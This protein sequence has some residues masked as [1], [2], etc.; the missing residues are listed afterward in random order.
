MVFLKSSLVENLIVLVLCLSVLSKYGAGENHITVN[1]EEN[2]EIERQLR[3]LNKPPFKTIITKMGDTIDCV[4]IY[5]Q[6][7][8]DHPLLKDHKIQM[9]PSYF[10][11]DENISKIDSSATKVSRV[12]ISKFQEDIF[13]PAGT[14]PIRRTEKRDLI[15]FNMLKKS[16]KNYTN[17][18]PKSPMYHHF[19]SAETAG[20]KNGYYGA[21]AMFGIHSPSAT[22]EQFSTSQMWIQNG[23]SGELNSIE[24]GWAVYPELFKDHATRSFSYWTA[25]G[26][27]NTGCFNMLCPGFIQV[28]PNIS[29]GTVLNPIT[30]TGPREMFFSVYR[31]KKTHNWWYYIGK[32]DEMPI[33][34]WPK[35]LFSH[36]KSASIVRFGGVAGAKP[37]ERSPPMGNGNLPTEDYK[38]HKTGHMRYLQALD[39]DGHTHYFGSSTIIKKDLDTKTDCYDIIFHKTKF[40]KRKKH[41]YNSMIFGGPGGNCI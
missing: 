16:K 5:K 39:E 3:I 13:C 9:E 1:E 26:Y 7:A 14:V 17:E 41:G 24:T 15:F 8:F 18:Y 36:L 33:G 30:S 35:E 40:G 23:P 6:A 37:N 2:L 32:D 10:N 21:K 20:E 11:R 4:D 19:V 27:K 25:D 29:F 38:I 34:Y 31:D 22:P 28:H 12:L